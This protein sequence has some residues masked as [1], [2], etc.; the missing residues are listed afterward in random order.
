MPGSVSDLAGRVEVLFQAGSFAANSRQRYRAVWSA[1]SVFCD[2]AGIIEPTRD[3]GAAFLVSVGAGD[4]VTAT[5][6]NKHKRRAVDYLFTVAETGVLPVPA[7][8][9]SCRPMVP[10][11]FSAAMTAW[12]DHLTGGG[13]AV[14]TIAHKTF[15]AAVFLSF[16]DEVRVDS[17]AELRVHHVHRYAAARCEGTS[18]AGLAR[19]RG[20][21]RFLVDLGI[22]PAEIG[23]VFPVIHSRRAAALPSVFTVEEVARAL[24]SITSRTSCWHPDRASLVRRDRAMFLL[25]AV[26]GLRGGDIVDLRKTD[27][28]WQE[29]RLSRRQIKTGRHLV[30]PI[31]QEVL[32]ALADYMKYERPPSDD[33]HVFLLAR[34]PY[35]PYRSKATVHVVVADAFKRAGVDITGRRHGPHA[36]RHSLASAMLAAGTSYPVIGAVLGHKNS[37]EATRAYLRIDVEHLR[38]LALEVPDEC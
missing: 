29:S 6:Q 26:L 16:L 36:L 7:S 18:L 8:R 4:P 14:E 22:V 1:F 33:D 19:L 9:N 37:S 23:G 21:L 15:V 12:E 24:D 32:L 35:Q 20:F 30:L 28:N 3:D 17:L 38:P 31:P 5:R 25:A 10:I 13:L 11:R 27:I 2:D 34:A